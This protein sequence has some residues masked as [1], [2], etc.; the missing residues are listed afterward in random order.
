VLQYVSQAFVDEKEPSELYRMAIDGMLEELGDPHTAFMPAEDYENLRIQT[1]GEYG[2][3]GISIA[4]RAGWITVITPLPG[5]PGE[6]A[7]LRAGDQIV[8][9]E[10]E[11][12][13][14]WTEDYAV[15]QLR[16]PKGEK[17]NIKI[18]RMGMEAP[19]P[20]TIVRDEIHVASVPA[21]YMI[22]DGVGYVELRVF[23]ETSTE[24]VRDA[25][26][27]LQA[28]GAKG[29]VLDMRLNSGGLLEEGV[30]V[31]DLFLE[32]GQPVVDTKG[33]FAN[34]T[35]QLV[36]SR[37]DEFTGLPVVVGPGSASATEI[38][39]GALQDHD[40]A[41]ILGRPTFG[42][43]SVQTVFRMP[44]NNWLK[45]TTAR[46]YT[47]SGRSIQRPYGIDQ[48]LIDEMAEGAASDMSTEDK[49][50]YMTDGG[51]T[52]YGGGGINPDLTVWPDT[53]T[54]DERALIEVLQTQDWPR[55][56]ETRFTYG[57]EFAKQNPSLKPGFTVTDGMLTGFYD[58]LVA[59][60]FDVDS[61][62]YE[63]GKRWIGYQ[64]A[65]EITYSQWGE[66][67]RRR[68]EN[69]DDPQIRTAVELLREASTP[70]SL[71]SLAASREGAN[72]ARGELLPA[73][74]R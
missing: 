18:A 74:H 58:R 28:E 50:E 53:T 65:S 4:K 61:G 63:A 55:F 24:E 56:I 33:R 14:E 23:S 35:Q 10:G 57:V 69:S 72:Q 62:V 1:Q 67:Q 6:R 25:I 52:V 73:G 71:F 44:D 21:A 45:I 66:E 32:S 36:A 29:I 41:L 19:I 60:G 26:T 9:V 59:A 49:P 34:N 15:S 7:G 3:I 68:R 46:W 54:L 31:S 64:L 16:G 20:F 27:K 70:A 42:K 38:V 40:R 8:E 2:G 13:R 43:G 39:A 22:D 47:P 37:E 11:S 51:R 5:T 17:V 30:S 48:P 12:T